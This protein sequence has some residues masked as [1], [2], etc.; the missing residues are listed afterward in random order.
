MRVHVQVTVEASP[1]KVLELVMDIDRFA[2]VDDEMD[3]S[4][5]LWQ[6]RVSTLTE[7]D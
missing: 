5:A 7:V 1:D 4:N 3:V 2:E 6:R